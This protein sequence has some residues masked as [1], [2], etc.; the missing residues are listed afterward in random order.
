M[1]KRKMRLRYLPDMKDFQLQLYQVCRLIK[2]YLPDLYQHFD[3]NEVTPTLYAAPWILTIFSSSFPLG[4]FRIKF[5]NLK[6]IIVNYIY[7]I[8]FVARV[9]D[10][11]FF[12]SDEVIFRVV[13]SLLDVHKDE[14]LRLNCFEDIMEYLKNIVPQMEE[15]IMNKVFMKVY[16]LNMLTRQLADYNI[17]YSVLK[18]EIAMQVQ[19]ETNLNIAKETNL[20]LEKQLQVTQSNIDRLENLRH[21]QQHENQLLKM[22]VRSSFV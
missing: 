16:S 2:D 5:I 3:T 17:E 4:K 14:L 6:L 22:Q 12:A 15:S 10:L 7:S 13:L 19:N 8:G 9:F 21:D 20:C 11:L 18:E 1:F